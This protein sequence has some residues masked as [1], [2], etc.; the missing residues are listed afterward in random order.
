MA[1]TRT[2]GPVSPETP[3]SWAGQAVDLASIERELGRAWREAATSGAVGQAP[4]AT[5]TNVLNLIV[6]ASS[7]EEVAHVADLIEQLGVHH[8]SRTLILLAQPDATGDALDAWVKTHV[9][10][11]PGTNRRLAFEQ[12]TIAARGAA[13]H[14]LPT[15]ADPLLISELPNFLW[16]LNDPPFRTHLFTQMVDIVDRLIVDSTCFRNPDMGFH[17]LSEV[18]VIPAGAAVSDF[19]WG[20]LG[21]WRELIA[22][23]FDPPA[24]APS[25]TAIEVVEVAY[26]PD[27]PDGMSGI[28]MG[29]LALGW[30]CSRLGWQVQAPARREAGGVARWTLRAGGRAIEA[31]LR[32]EHDGDG[33]GGLRSLTL[34]AGGAQPGT[35]LLYR[36]STKHLATTVNVPGARQPDRLMRATVLEERDLLLHDLNQFGHDR[37]YEGALV[38]AAQ[39]ARGITTV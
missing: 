31:T 7:D 33:I 25:L 2:D 22:Q 39:L 19:A 28:S 3:F 1:S 8:P 21:P 37:L 29:I 26:E 9:H 13:A 30:L 10:D 17:E 5:R 6:H 27:G 12:V 18:S 24:L 4:L 15:I 35:F 38:F 34:T 11:L 16:W 20:R 23:F 36:E 32:P 14:S